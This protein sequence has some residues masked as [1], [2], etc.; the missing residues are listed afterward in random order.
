[1]SATPD[2]ASKER[3]RART[4][5]LIGAALVGI[6]VLTAIR[7]GP[8]LYA[9]YRFGQ[10]VEDF[11]RAD[12]AGGGAWPRVSDACTICHGFNGNTVTQLYARL[13]GQPA[14]Y[15]AAQLNAYAS[16]ERGDATM[17]PLARTMSAQEIRSLADYFAGRTP[18]RNAA[19]R[20][21]P[22]KAAEG[23]ALA[24]AGNCG[25]CHGPTLEGHDQFPRL[26]GQGHDYLVAQLAAFRS[27]QRRDPTGGMN[28]LAAGLSNDAIENLAQ[29][30][31]SR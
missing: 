6:A 10:A 19:F 12:Q 13:A 5:W 18:E 2:I 4:W 16:G 3:G 24:T 25:S 14:A 29:Y 11:A 1:M 15:L 20:A 7:Y 17:A 8:D 30:L 23:A 21:N 27:G 9:Y 28:Q 26:A 31:A 22:A